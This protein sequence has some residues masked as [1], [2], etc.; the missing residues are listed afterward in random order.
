MAI[1]PSGGILD[2]PVT[3]LAQGGKSASR[4]PSRHVLNPVCASDI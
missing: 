4:H 1:D 3:M 2:M